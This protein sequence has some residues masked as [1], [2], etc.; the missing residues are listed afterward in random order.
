MCTTVADPAPANS[1]DYPTL[2]I[3]AKCHPQLWKPSATKKGN[4]FCSRLLIPDKTKQNTYPVKH[5]YFPVLSWSRHPVAI[6]MYK[7]PVMFSLLSRGS[8]QL[9]NIFES[10]VLY[11]RAVGP[12]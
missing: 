5:P 12:K 7:D 4:G 1:Y 2:T 10:G 3:H 11:A 9:T 8:T 6:V